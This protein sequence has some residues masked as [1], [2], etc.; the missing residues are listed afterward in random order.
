[1]NLKIHGLGGFS[2]NCRGYR[3]NR[4]ISV[5]SFPSPRI[6]ILMLSKNSDSLPKKASLTVIIHVLTAPMKITRRNT[7]RIPLP[8]V[9]LS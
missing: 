4:P 3:P 2:L 6:L 8:T 7:W 9:G 1:M 5:L